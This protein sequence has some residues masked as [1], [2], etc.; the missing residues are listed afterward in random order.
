M[1]SL[2]RKA[3]SIHLQG[4]YEI[5]D[6]KKPPGTFWATIFPT[7]HRVYLFYSNMRNKAISQCGLSQTS[8]NGEGQCDPPVQKAMRT[9][10]E[11]LFP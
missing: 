6:M 5:K 11:I 4:D 2:I 9:T 7:N 8:L 10:F 3:I 1:P